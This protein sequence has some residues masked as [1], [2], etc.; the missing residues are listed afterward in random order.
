M[1]GSPRQR[2]HHFICATTFFEPI[3][4]ARFGKRLSKS[5]CA[6]LGGLPMRSTEQQHPALRGN[7]VTSG[8]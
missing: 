4:K 7:D 5:A 8:A 6:A 1:P 2:R 3:P